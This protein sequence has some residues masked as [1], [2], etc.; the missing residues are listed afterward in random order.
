MKI[1]KFPELSQNPEH[2]KHLARTLESG[3]LV[4][5]P[6]G[7]T[8]RILANLLDEDA[9]INL[10]QSKRRTSKAPSLVFLPDV[11]SLSKVTDNIPDLASKLAR[12]LWP[13]PLTILFDPGD[14]IPRSVVKQICKANGHIGVRVPE[15]E[16]LLQLLQE[17]GGPVLVSSA[18]KEKKQGASSP[19]QIRKNFVSKVDLFVDAGDLSGNGSS[20]IVEIKDGN[21]AVTREG[22]VSLE[23]LKKYT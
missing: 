10:M 14:D 21:L 15:D 22:K 18:N 7:G 12:D 3:G 23:Q 13:G 6:C 20:T 9:V 11:K 19:A 2:Y 4:C 16:A 8:Y 1:I 17:F 5:V